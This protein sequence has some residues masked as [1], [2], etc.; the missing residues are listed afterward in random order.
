MKVKSKKKF[1]IISSEFEKEICD[2]I[3]EKIKDS[4]E[5]LTTEEIKEIISS[6]MPDLDK[7]ISEKIK[8]HIEFLADVL[9]HSI[10]REE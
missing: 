2:L 9:L 10:K 3:D 1:S 6:L 8:F 5:K 4:N 7:L